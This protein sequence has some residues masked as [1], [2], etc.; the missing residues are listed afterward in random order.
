MVVV[1]LAGRGEMRT[2]AAAAT[3]SEGVATGA[4]GGSQGVAA[5]CWGAGGPGGGAREMTSVVR[6]M[7]AERS[8]LVDVRVTLGGITEETEMESAARSSSARAGPSRVTEDEPSLCLTNAGATPLAASELR[9]VMKLRAEEAAADNLAGT[10]EAV[11]VALAR[12]EVPPL[13]KA[14]L[15]TTRVTWA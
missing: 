3:K 14:P 6:A 2:W 9:E 15:R 11:V 5:V 1:S 4:V 8:M 10:I 7:G 13:E 12:E